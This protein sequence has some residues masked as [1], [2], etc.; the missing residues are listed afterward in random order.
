MGAII[1]PFVVWYLVPEPSKWRYPF[2]VIGTLGLVW[3]ALWLVTGRPRDM[4]RHEAPVADG[5]PAASA[6]SFLADRRFW[7]LGVVTV[8]INMAWQFFRAWL[9][10][11]LKDQGF[12]RNVYIL[13]NSAYYIAADAGSIAAPATISAAA[14]PANSSFFMHASMSLTL[15]G[16]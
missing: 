2:W 10:T 6:F 8:T 9:T 11:F 12:E 3:V 16:A 7:V 13:F 14:A 4:A 1:T 15:A 5:T